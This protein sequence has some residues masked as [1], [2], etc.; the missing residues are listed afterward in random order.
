MEAPPCCTTT[1][2]DSGALSRTFRHLPADSLIRVRHHRSPEGERERL[3]SRRQRF[4]SP[5]SPAA[6]AS[7]R[8]VHWTPSCWCAILSQRAAPPP[9]LSAHCAKVSLHSLV[10]TVPLADP[11][12]S[13]TEPSGCSPAYPGPM[14]TRSASCPPRRAA[15]HA[16]GYARL[17]PGF[18]Y[19]RT[20]MSRVEDK[21]SDWWRCRRLLALELDCTQGT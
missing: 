19:R 2:A 21:A 10:F 15:T 1:R 3:L 4:L 12:W 16:V 18:C 8:R 17:R 5:A 11:T 20:T 7:T 14:R 9:P 13:A 6:L